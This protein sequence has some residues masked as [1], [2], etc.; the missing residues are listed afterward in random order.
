M[1][2][3][4]GRNFYAF[5][6]HAFW[7]ALSK[8]FAETNTVLPALILIIGGTQF[9][10]G[11]LTSILIGI[12]LITQLIFA[13]YLNNK[14]LKKKYLLLGIYLRVLALLGVA[15]ILLK[16]KDFSPSLIIILIFAWMFLFALSGAFAGISYIDILG[17]SVKGLQRK[18]FL[19]FRQFLSGTGLFISALIARQILK[20]FK[21]P[22]NY[23]IF[24]FASATLLFVA[25][26]GFIAIR[27]KPSNIDDENVAFKEIIRSIPNVLRNDNNI[28]NLIIGVNLIGLIITLIPFFV[29]LI[30]TQDKIN[31]SMIGNFLLFQIIGM[32]ISNY[33]WLK[34][35]KKSSYKGVFKIAIVLHSILPIVALVFVYYLPYYLFSLVFLLNGIAF[36][37]FRIASSGALLEISN[38]T[39]RPLYSGI[40]GAFNITFSIFPLI[41]GAL[42]SSIGY[43]PLFIG[44]S[45]FSLLSLIFINKLNC[46]KQEPD[47]TYLSDKNPYINT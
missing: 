40:Y 47:Q 41:I 19:V 23:M 44:A 15:S 4:E 22:S 24:F 1:F 16:Y 13:G 17:K 35:V 45:F 11:I 18:R 36:S 20:S 29:V 30:K 25:S 43:V 26:F 3:K 2:R 7:F 46:N 10:V 31:S 37:G 34:V 12:P 32:T 42:I 8:T 5:E 38:E 27:E 14:K 39:N 28:K 21:Y 6:W 9:Q 33:V